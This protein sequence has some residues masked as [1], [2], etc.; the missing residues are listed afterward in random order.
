M[1]GR[2]SRSTA[3]RIGPDRAVLL[4]IA[5]AL[6]TILK[7][8]LFIELNLMTIQQLDNFALMHLNMSDT[9]TD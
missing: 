3:D 5:P 2:R 9:A 1:A 6:V 4:G 8:V 7:Q